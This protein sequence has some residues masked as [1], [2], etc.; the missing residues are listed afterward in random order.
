VDP[1]QDATLIRM[2]DDDIL[3]HAGKVVFRVNRFDVF[4]ND[5]LLHLLA[6]EILPKVNRDSLRLVRLVLRGAASPEGPYAN[7]LRLSKQRAQTLVDFLRARLSVPVD[8]SVLSVE[9]VAEDYYL[10]CALMRRANDPDHWVVNNL[11]QHHVPHYQF[12]LLKQRLQRLQHGRLWPRLLREYFPELRAARLVL[13]FEKP[14]KPISEQVAQIKI[15]P[16]EG[17]ISITTTYTLAK[18]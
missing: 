16:I 6:D 10:L 12:T 4:T 18:S 8:E 2:S 9:T 5:S 17:R 13:F 1:E 15:G 11:V 14:V 3:D 7:N